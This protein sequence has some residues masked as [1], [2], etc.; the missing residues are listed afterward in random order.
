MRC[1]QTFDDDNTFPENIHLQ[2]DAEAGRL[3]SHHEP[4]QTVLAQV[5]S[6]NQLIQ[7]FDHIFNPDETV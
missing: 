2:L 3:G 7:F 5:A 1:S 4:V 6:E